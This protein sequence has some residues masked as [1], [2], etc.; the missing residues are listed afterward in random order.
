[1]EPLNEKLKAL[2]LLDLPAPIDSFKIDGRIYNFF[3][4]TKVPEI[5]KL[6]ISLRIL[7]E[8]CLRYS[9][10]SKDKSIG[11]VWKDSAEKIL[12]R[13]QGQDVLFQPGRVVLQDFTGKL[14]DLEMI[15]PYNL[16]EL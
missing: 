14:E 15:I 16:S 2:G 5:Q 4:L 1:M 10:L 12:L 7:Y 8:S 9:V 13:E 6:P 11:Q 3:D